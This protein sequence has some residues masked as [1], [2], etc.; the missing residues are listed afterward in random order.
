MYRARVVHPFVEGAQPAPDAETMTL[1]SLFI[2]IGDHWALG[3]DPDP[4]YHRL[5]TFMRNRINVNPLY[6]DS[7]HDGAALIDAMVAELGAKTAFD[8]ILSEKPRIPPS[9]T[10]ATPLEALQRFV[11][12]EFIAFRLAAGSFRAFGAINY[13]GY[14]AG[15]NIA[16]QP[17]PYRSKDHV[18]RSIR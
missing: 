9:G 8:K 7:Y 6:P 17:I 15:A 16:D 18:L 4:Y 3:D 11:V 14:P 5:L 13:P 1:W 12:N 10:P 2:A